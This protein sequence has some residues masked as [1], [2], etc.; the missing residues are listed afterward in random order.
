MRPALLMFGYA[1]AVAWLTPALLSRLT[2]RGASPRLGLAAWLTAMASAVGAAIAALWFLAGA[3]VS[4]WPG[5]AQTV[6]RAVA[7]QVCA[8]TMYRSALFELALAIAAALAVAAAAVAAWRYGRGV[9]RAQARARVHGQAARIA[10]RA[11]APAPPREHAAPHHAAPHH[12]APHHAAQQR[13]VVLDAPQPAAYCVP[14]RPAT[15]VLTTAAL[16]ILDADQLTAV[17]AHER[18]HLAGRHHLLTGLTRGL[19]AVFPAV[20]L[21][22]RGPL[23]VAR[24]AELRADDAAARR[25]GRRT[26][27]AALLAMGTGAAVPAAALAATGG[28][29]AARVQRLLDPPARTARGALALMTVTL[30]LAAASAAIPALAA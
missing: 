22:A 6:C 21:F 2:A 9:Q 12:A 25:S 3:A 26:L 1:L 11:M 10:G 8:P 13:A 24:L 16:A 20:P 14:G 29:T 15:I 5:L 17:L 27:V 28:S 30:L 23:E 18:A 19:A 7:G 4:G